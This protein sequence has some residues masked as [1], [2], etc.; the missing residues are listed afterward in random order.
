MDFIRIG[1]CFILFFLSKLLPV[2]LYPVGFITIALFLLAA[3]SK[4]YVIPKLR[5][6]LLGLSSFSWGISTPKFTSI[7]LA[8]F[9][10]PYQFSSVES[11]PES[12]VVV[13]LGG[14]MSQHKDSKQGPKMNDSV[15]RLVQGFQVLQQGKA[16][17]LLISG[18]GSSGGCHPN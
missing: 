5:W 2:F 1:D 3:I 10:S 18:C 14:I 6:V 11:L 17:F 16:K 9:E 7:L 15:E 12:D 8:Q 13:V 4:T